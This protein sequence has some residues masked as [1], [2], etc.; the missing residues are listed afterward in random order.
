MH[1][2]ITKSSN[3]RE[4]QIEDCSLNHA[5]Q[6]AKEINSQVPLSEFGI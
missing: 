4:L 5:I 1:S 6:I 3:L 2:N